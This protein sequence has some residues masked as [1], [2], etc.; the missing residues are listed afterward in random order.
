MKG[1]TGYRNTMKRH[2]LGQTALALACLAGFATAANAQDGTA[3]TTDDNT[4]VVVTGSRLANRGFKAP[5]PVTIVDQKDIKLTG[6][7]NLDT[8][9]SDTPQFTGSQLNSPTANTVQAGQPI[10]T[11]TLNL[12]DLGPTRNLV[13]VNGRRFAITG[14]DFTTDIN[15]IPAVLVKRVETVTGGSSAVYGSDAIAGVVNFIMRDDF[16]GVDLNLQRTWDQHTNTPT[17]TVDLTFGG[18]FD[19]GRGNMVVSLDYMDRHGYTRAD[20]GGWALPSLGDGCVTAA[21]WSDDH[22]GVPMTVPSGQT[23]LSAGGKPGLIFSGSSTVPDGRI[24]NL[25]TV[26]SSSSNPGLDAALIAAGLQNMTSLG[27]I[28]DSTGKTVRP[29]VAPTDAYDLGPLSYIVTPQ[30]RWMGNVF[31]HYDFN[32]HATGY[33]ELHYSD[34]VADVQI[35]PTSASG[36][37]LVDVNNPYLSQQ[38]RDVLQQLDMKETGTTNVT[39]GTQTLSTTPNDGR[40]VLNLNRRLP[41][42]GT[43]FSTSDHS[44]FRVALG[45]KGALGDVSPS[46]LRDLHYDVYYTF[47]QTTESDTQTGS[48]SL[49]HFQTAILSQGGAA[50]VCNPF[51]QNMTAACAAAIS[52]SANAGLRAEQQVFAGNLTGSLF[53]LPAGPV[54]FSTGFEWRYDFGK[55]IPDTYLASGDVSGWN[56]ARATQGSTT[57]K[58]LYGEFRAPIV[59]G[60]T[61]V[62]R[63]SLNGAF[64]YSDY[65]TPGVGGVWTYSIGSEWAVNDDLAFR[66]QF[67]HA[68]RAPNAGELYGGRGTNGPSASDPCSSRGTTQTDAVKAV[69]IATGVPANLVFDP[70]IQPSNFIT[71]V[72]GGNVNLSPEKSNTTTFGMVLTPQALHG[73]EFSLDYYRITLDDAIAPLGGG[74][75]QSVLNMCY[76]TLQDANSVYC[77][78]IHRDSTGQIAGPDYVTTT[79]A[80]IGGIKTSGIDIEG[81]YGFSTDWGLMGASRWDIAE[82]WT[83]VKE[84]TVTPDQ[85]MPQIQNKCVGAFGGTCGQPIPKW[86]GNTR[87]TWATGPLTLSARVRYLGKATIDTVIIPERQGKTYPALNTLTNPVVPAYTYVDLTAAYDFSSKISLTVG[88]RNLFDKDPPVLGSSQLPADNTDPIAYDVEGRTFFVNLDTK[89]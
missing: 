23:C 75:L 16:Q 7:Q 64:R 55:Y 82:D 88:I 25:P 19:N 78:A 1:K 77:K 65:D 34:N 67:Q 83:Y 22:A 8:M 81:H 57:V 85:T 21:S 38:M 20:R 79:N 10:G 12:R 58:E 89:F 80:N 29:Y 32:D 13:L 17:S 27:A 41:D 66:A 35:A 9:L 52:I 39:E 72:L 87:L 73:L 44:V 62:K 36:N 54:D 11:A 59:A 40:V 26:G 69:C 56:A 14:P 74:G 68:I 37:F 5:T 28:F 15:T 30:R 70:A 46:F 3:K 18:N 84:F 42:I 60:V 31:A 2:L 45:V 33:M 53:D 48:I 51:G 6:A 4:V 43:R 76:Y 71:Q 63:L 50:P 47:A 49:S 24:G 61:G 86:K